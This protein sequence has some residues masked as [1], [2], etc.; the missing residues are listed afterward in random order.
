MKKTISISAL[1]FFFISHSQVFF[2]QAPPPL[3]KAD[4][5]NQSQTIWPTPPTNKFNNPA[6]TFELDYFDTSKPMYKPLEVF[7]RFGEGQYSKLVMPSNTFGEDADVKVWIVDHYDD[8]DDPPI[9]AG[10]HGLV[11]FVSPPPPP[12][13]TMTNSHDISIIPVWSKA[14]YGDTVMYIIRISTNCTGKEEDPNGNKSK[15]QICPGILFFEVTNANLALQ[16]NTTLGTKISAL[17]IDR[18]GSSPPLPNTGQSIVSI[19]VTLFDGQVTEYLVGFHIQDTKVLDKIP[20]EVEARISSRCCTWTPATKRDTLGNSHDP[21]QKTVL[22]PEVICMEEIN[23]QIRIVYKVEYQNIGTGSAKQVTITDD[24]DQKDFILSVDPLL[25]HKNNS[26]PQPFYN[27][28]DKS[29]RWHLDFQNNP[30]RGTAEPNYMI[31]F[32]EGATKSWLTFEV[33]Y[34]NDVI[35]KVGYC[36]ALMNQVRIVFDC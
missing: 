11:A 14:M 15:C 25:A 7:W 19:P 30:L 32:Q 9:S 5:G 8:D 28:A 36:G 18:V 20:L 10:Y 31:D 29:I 34:H 22:S 6:L 21:N 16:D 1:L 26:S 2:A 27:S 33:F 17:Y 12:P 35:N 24:L 3:I 13:V 4:D 23:D